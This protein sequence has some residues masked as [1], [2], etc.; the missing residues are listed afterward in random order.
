MQPQG[1]I[2]LPMLNVLYRYYEN[3]IVGVASGF[4][5]T[6][7]QPEGNVTIKKNGNLFIA[8]PGRGRTAEIAIYGKNTVN[9]QKVK[10]GVQSFRVMDKPKPTVKLG[11]IE[12]GQTGV[13]A[14]TIKNITK[15]FMGYQPGILLTC[16]EKIKTYTIDVNGHTV[17]GTGDVLNQKAKDLLRMVKPGN[18]ITITG[19]YSGKISGN[20][21]PFTIKVR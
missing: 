21:L 3:E 5:E 12:S 1:T 15:L 10:L 9:N 4:D 11:N 7:M 18:T 2:S 20:F 16:D 17:D 13:D 6:I 8:E 14:I 19:T